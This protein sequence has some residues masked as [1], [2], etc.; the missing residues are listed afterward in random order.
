VTVQPQRIAVSPALQAAV[1]LWRSGCAREAELECQALLSVAT[2]EPG[3]LDLLAEI[4]NATGRPRLAA[5]TLQRLTRLAPYDA[6]TQRRLGDAWLAAGEASAALAAFRRSLEIEPNSA[7]AHNNLGRALALLGHTR[8]AL[9]EYE[10][11]LELRVDYAIAHNNR[12]LVLVELGRI[13]EALASY[14]HAMALDAELWEAHYN[15]GNAL[16]R[17]R[18][19][20]EALECAD[21]AIS[22]R[23]DSAQAHNVR[24]RA[25]RALRRYEEARIACER[26]TQIEPDWAAGW[27]HR[28]AL[29]DDLCDLDTARACYQRVLQIDPRCLVARLRLL[30]SYIPIIAESDAEVVRSRRALEQELTRF[31]EWLRGAA[32]ADDEAAELVDQ[33]FYLSYQEHSN[34]AL[35]ERYR[36]TCVSLMTR[37]QAALAGD[38]ADDDAARADI[39]CGGIHPVPPPIDIRRK[40]VRVAIV[41][42]HLIDHSVYKAL[43]QGWLRHLDRRRFEFHLFH[44]GAYQDTET[45]HAAALSDRFVAGAR[46]LGEWVAAIHASDPDVLIFPEVGMDTTTLRLAALRLAPHQLAAWGHPETTGL[47]TID[48]YLS[49]EAFEPPGAESHYSERLHRLPRLGCCYEPYGSAVAEPDGTNAADLH[50]LLDSAPDAGALLVC[51]GVPFK[52]APQHDRVLAQIARRLGRCRFVFFNHPTTRASSRLAARLTGMFERG[53]LAPERYLRFVPWLPRAQF[54]ELLRRA[55]ACLDTIG[56]SGFNTAMQSVECGLP[57]IAY[58]GSYMRGRFASGVLETLGLPELVAEHE[59]GYVERVVRLAEDG[60]WRALLREELL[61]RRACV[62]ADRAPVAALERLLLDLPP[63]SG[64]SS[65]RQAT[66]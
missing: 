47:P 23:P 8:E 58:R 50:A 14:R 16:L 39:A 24:G 26:A 6:A 33:F 62:F 53:G 40:E 48:H 28:G 64:R 43:V 7:R 54:F 17:L 60:A 52:Y 57:I 35:L 45:S 59:P 56:F 11:A 46:T 15:C 21:R 32:V 1:D 10:H 38:A 22:L 65:A 29:L 13:E 30:T 4:Y 25:L 12:G 31:E 19:A 2:S 63:V 9:R 44:V 37:W 20:P 42:A 3:P 41:S 5:C 27:L 51:P 34:R 55:D 36:G 61:S 18:R 49:A 66:V